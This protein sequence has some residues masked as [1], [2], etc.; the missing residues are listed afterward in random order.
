MKINPLSTGIQEKSSHQVASKIAYFQPQIR[1]RHP[2][3]SGL[4]TSLQKL[5]FRSIVRFGSTTEVKDNI[6]RVELNSTEAIENSSNKLLMK[7][8]FAKG[9]VKTAD[10]TTNPA[11]VSKITENWKYACVVKQHFG[12][13]GKGNTLVKTQGEFDAFMKGRDSNHY[14]F[15]KFYNYTREY[16][17]HVNE[18]GC[19][20]TCRKMLKSDAP[21]NASWFRNDSNCVWYLETNSSFDKPTNWDSV[22]KDSVKALKA[23]GLDFGA[24]DLRIQSAKDG[25]GKVRENPDYIVVEI[26]SAPGMNDNNS[27]VFKKYTEVL[28]VMLKKKFLKD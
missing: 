1:S 6:K 4:R 10:W 28:P 11:E 19:F 15:E 21:E 5:P 14:I 3:H 8:C 16:R 25:K 26:N 2:S 23:V 9:N 7:R 12:S 13:R 17:L 27:V 24:V 20:Y 22:V 18:E